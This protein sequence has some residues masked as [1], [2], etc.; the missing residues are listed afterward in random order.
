MTELN[1]IEFQV[2]PSPET[3]DHEVKIRLYEEPS[4]S[5]RRANALDAAKPL[6]SEV[7]SVKFPKPSVLK[8]EF[9]ERQTKNRRS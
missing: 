5:R 8:G 1:T 9:N 3:N 6:S 4:A 2:V 7:S